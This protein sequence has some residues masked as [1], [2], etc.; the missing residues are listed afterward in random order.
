M[1]YLKQM[2]HL[3]DDE[4]LYDSVASDDDYAALVTPFPKV[5]F[6]FE[7]QTTRF[8]RNIIILCVIIGRA[9]FS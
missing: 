7:M 8:F 9:S 5:R 1:N 2:T 4:P 3:S 6:V